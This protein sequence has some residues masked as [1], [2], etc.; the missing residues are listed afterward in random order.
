MATQTNKPRVL[1]IGAGLGGLTLAQCLRKQEIPFEIYERDTNLVSRSS[2][3]A[4]GIHS[5]LDD[6]TSSV[7][8]DLPPLKDAVNHLLP[9]TLEA[10]ICLYFRGTRLAVQHT[11]EAP[12][13]RANRFRFREWLSTR[14]AIQ[15]GKR[16]TQVEEGHGEVRVRFQDGMTATGDILVGADG[17]NSIVREHVLQRPNK[18]TLRTVPAAIIIGETT[19]S[20]ELFKHQLSLGHSCYVNAGPGN[21]YVFVGLSQVNPDG[22]SGKYYWFFIGDDADVGN[23][24]HWLRSASQSEKL[25]H[26]IKTTS[27]LKPV[28]TEVIKSTTPS[29][30]REI[31][32]IV[33][34][35]EIHDL[36]VGRI[37]LLG[38]SVHPMTPFRGEGGVHAL[39]DALNLGKVLGQLRSNDSGE[40]ESL[41]G[42]YQKEMLERGAAAVKASRD[43]QKVNVGGR[44]E[45]MSWGQVAVPTPEET[46][47]LEDCLP[48]ERVGAGCPETTPEVN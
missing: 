6:L 44:G 37:T 32:I 5:V 28:F 13:I 4:I 23:E 21:Y 40:I 14:I 30:I 34:D 36:P 16:V 26:V 11:P 2:G 25:E 39:R 33:R 18:E 9:L 47:S 3:W 31:P 45:L 19:M 27:T 41:L 20:G 43:A 17:V 7:P 46:I 35:A 42:P 48:E 10:Q 38:D 8:Q 1:I 22:K 24:D 12:V 29:G 15:W